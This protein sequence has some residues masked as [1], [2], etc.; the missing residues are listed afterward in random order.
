MRFSL[1]TLLCC[2]TA[3]LSAQGPI[4]FTVNVNTQQITQTDPAIF[5]T[6]EK[7]L[8]LFLN[9]TPWS[10]DRF[11]EDERIEA[12][13]F[14]TLREVFEETN[15][16]D[17]VV[18]NAFR[19]TV[20]L[21][22]L[23][24]IYGIGEQTPILNYQDGD[25]QFSYQQ[26]E[27]IQISEQN[28]TTEL[29]SVF[30]FYA[31]M[32]LGY[33]YDTFSPLGGEPYFDKALE[34]YNRL[35]GNVQNQDGWQANKSRN[36]F[37]WLTNIQNPRMLPLRRAYYTYHRTGLDLMHSDPLAGRQNI[38][39][40]I[41]DAKTASQAI[42]NTISAQVF[43]DAKREE[44]IAIY[45]GATGV[46]QNAVISAMSRMDPSKSGEYRKIRYTPTSRRTPTSGRQ[47][48]TAN[49]LRQSGRQ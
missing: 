27:A 34:L 12:S 48:S 14:L 25:V 33:D 46:E 40:A 4:N 17:V 35:P 38:T 45:R 13:V 8:T 49:R 6:L 16:G 20:A 47:P 21:Q 5:K 42:I 41:E 2:L 23:R 29:A 15:N 31:Y 18:P 22:S 37:F 24:P 28:F 3:L 36:R 39:L 11:L 32:I 10:D 19:A 7:D 30:A 44:I 43:V 9:G 1:S 26:F